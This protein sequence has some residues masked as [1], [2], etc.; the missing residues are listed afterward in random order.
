MICIFGDSNVAG[1]K[2]NAMALYPK[3]KI[4]TNILQT[5]I[6]SKIVSDGQPGRF[7]TKSLELY[8]Q[9]ITI[10]PKICILL[11]G[12][13]DLRE[14][15]YSDVILAINLFFDA[16]YNAK[17]YFIIHPGIEYQKLGGFWDCFKDTQENERL[18]RKNIDQINA[19][20]IDLK[21]LNI[22][23]DDG[24]HFS[25]EGHQILADLVH[26]KVK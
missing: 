20:L 10:Q 9:I 14:I 18:F 12:L 6:S 2:P 3:A 15:L 8:K 1:W 17:N 19:E 4:W 11:I 25:E 16:S 23:G 24:I 5:K 21:D 22:L 26:E 13:N 7:A